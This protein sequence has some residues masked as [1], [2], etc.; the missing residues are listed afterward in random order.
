MVDVHNLIEQ[1]KHGPLSTGKLAAV[2]D[3]SFEL[4]QCFDTTG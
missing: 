4:L 2:R 3:M 1:V